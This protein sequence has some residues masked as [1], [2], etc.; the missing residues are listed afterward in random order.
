MVEI[1]VEI[2]SNALSIRVL[3]LKWNEMCWGKICWGREYFIIDKKWDGISDD[4]SI[5]SSIY[6][7]FNR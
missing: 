7:I 6:E 1:R 5:E 4:R 3:F 2:S